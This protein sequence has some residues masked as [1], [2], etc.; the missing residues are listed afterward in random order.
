MT[1]RPLDGTEK[2]KAG[3][4][5][6]CRSPPVRFISPFCFVCQGRGD[7]DLAAACAEQSESWRRA[8]PLRRNGSVD[9]QCLVVHSS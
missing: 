1:R 4:L 5:P 8:A 3:L 6:D 2:K 9:S 7:G